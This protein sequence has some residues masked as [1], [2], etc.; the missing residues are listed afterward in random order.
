MIRAVAEQRYFRGLSDAPFQKFASDLTNVDR[1]DPSV[2]VTD[3]DGR[4]LA[5]FTGSEG[6]FVCEEESQP[7]ERLSESAWSFDT[8]ARAIC[9]CADTQP[10]PRL[11]EQQRQRLKLD[12]KAFE[13]PPDVE[14]QV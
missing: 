2:V 12:W 3:A 13:N 14:T 5:H 11:A 6:R 7:E 8:P 1:R 10:A 9:Q 4:G